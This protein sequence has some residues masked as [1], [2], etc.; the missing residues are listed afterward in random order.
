MEKPAIALIISF[1][2]KIPIS[3]NEI[4]AIVVQN[5]QKNWY[6]AIKINEPIDGRFTIRKIVVNLQCLRV[7]SKSCNSL[8]WLMTLGIMD[9]I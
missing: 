3:S 8:M 5:R 7:T 9:T 2:Q 6:A 4:G 1:I